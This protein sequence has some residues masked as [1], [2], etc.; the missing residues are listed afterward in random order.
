MTNAHPPVRI[1]PG[2]YDTGDGYFNEE[3]H[4]VYDYE[5]RVLRVAALEEVKWITT[6]CRMA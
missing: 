6:K 1:P 5:G 3:N 4:T 2:M